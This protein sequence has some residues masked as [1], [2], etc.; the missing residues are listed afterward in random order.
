MVRSTQ[1]VHLSCIKIR[2]ISKQTELS[3]KPR[4]LGDWVCLAQTV[5]LS[6]TNSNTVSKEQEVRFHMTHIT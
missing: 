6:C 1:T 5:L 2:I 4:H 3:L